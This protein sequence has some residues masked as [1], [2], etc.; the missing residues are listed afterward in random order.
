MD[1]TSALIRKLGIGAKLDD[2]DISGIRSLP[3]AVKQLSSG[4]TIA[5]EGELATNCCLCIEGFI[6]RAKNTSDGHRQI[7]SVHI[8]GDMPDLQSLY[9]RVMDH[10]LIAMTQC[11]AGFVPHAAL[12]RLV[13]SRANVAEV[14]WRDTLIDSAIFREWM[15][16]LGQRDSLGRLAHL[17]LEMQ[18]RLD[19]VG[20]VDASSFRW[21]IVQ[22]QMGEALGISDVHVNRVL[23][24]LR[25]TGLIEV[26]GG[27]LTIL[28]QAGL[29]MVGQF[30]AAYLHEDQMH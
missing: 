21:P 15:V 2:E 26:H 27:M 28:D 7:L 23:K 9:L 29:M 10:D 5:S 25:E 18:R 1:I 20:M 12:R 17:V 3:V 13:R 11:T 30:D 8:P 16:N 24:E 14:L 4:E 6:Y 22:H 19:A